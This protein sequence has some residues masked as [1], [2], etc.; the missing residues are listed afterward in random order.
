METIL[1]RCQ[2][3]D[4]IIIYG[5]GSTA[6]VFCLYLKKR[7]LDHKV[8][9]FVV[10]KNLDN[11]TKKKDR[12]V[13]EIDDLENNTN[14]III[15]ATQKVT[16]KAIQKTLESKKI[17]NYCILDDEILLGEFYKEL[18]KKPIKS[19]T[20]MF[21]NI[22]GRGY[23]GNPKYIAEE[24]RRRNLNS[25][26]KMQLVWAV[27][28]RNEYNGIPNDIKVVE[29]GS[30]D[31]YEELAEAKV[32]VDNDRKS[33]DIR[34]RLGQVYIQAWHGAA[35]IKKVEKDVEDKLTDFYIENAKRDS[36]MADLF[37][38][39]S[40]FYTK[41]YRKSFWYSGE[42][43]KVGLPRQDIFWNMES[44]KNKVFDFYKI[45]MTSK[46]VLYAPTFRKDGNGEVYD[47]DIQGMIRSLEK[48]F[49]E[50]FVCAVS[51]HPINLAI[52]YNLKNSENIILVEKY[53]DF[54]ELLA[55]ADVLISDYSGCV[56]D[57]SFTKRP[58]FLYQKDIEAYKEDRNFYIPM[59]KLPYIKA[60]NNRQLQHEI[61]M[62]DD[63]LYQQNLKKF[64]ENMGNYDDGTAAQKVVDKIME[65]LE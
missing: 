16:H 49:K 25:E 50:S 28:D 15:V 4:S 59:E 55:A 62:Y 18:Y 20:I 3:K 64:M 30:E 5:A 44:I 21:K 61:E 32:W 29:I 41:L 46:L 19:N 56:Y 22:N 14:S 11:V 48:R 35:P 9:C 2:K 53:P 13:I 63:H 12:K 65:Y 45:P 34:K 40:E 7:K 52:R 38:S 54:Q 51:K 36:N 42:I 10:T 31:Y 33:N 57:F 47:L 43:M 39:G 58:V 17:Y 1:D 26:R 37:I 24:I 27:T 60:T 8:K 6:N 23:G